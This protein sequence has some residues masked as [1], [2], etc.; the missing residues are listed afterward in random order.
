MAADEFVRLHA[1]IEGHVQGVSFRYF[2]TRVA[3]GLGV[4][5]WVRNRYDGNVE[6]IAEGSRSSLDRLLVELRE[7]PPQAFVTGLKHEWLPATKEF[8]RFTVLHTA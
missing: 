3:E 8:P 4:T 2:V 1:T 7:G 5:G 6:V